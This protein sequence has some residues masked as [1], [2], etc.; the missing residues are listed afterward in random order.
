MQIVAASGAAAAPSS[1]SP[2]SFFTSASSESNNVQVAAQRRYIKLNP[3]GAP[4]VHALPAALSA[5]S[6]HSLDDTVSYLMKSSLT[7]AYYSSSGGAV[8]DSS[9][10]TPPIEMPST[11]GAPVSLAC[12][13][14]PAP[15]FD[16]VIWLRENGRVVPN[17]R[18]LLGKEAV[19]SGD[20]SNE[21]TSS[22][23]KY[24]SARGGLVKVKHE[25][26]SLL[27]DSK[28]DYAPDD[29]GDSEKQPQRQSGE[30]NNDNDDDDDEKE[31]DFSA[32]DTRVRAVDA[33]AASFMRSMLFIKSLRKEDLGLYKCR[34]VNAYGSRTVVYL[35]REKTLVGK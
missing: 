6:P 31:L 21:D 18:L 2:L 13:V 4:V 20:S 30:D 32:E 16:S 33:R 34:V 11:L 24:Y 12:L 1:S 22:I 14:E 7:D 29:D 10:S 25:N 9:S 8:S 15:G 19:V 28:L 5:F 35:V 17:S 27:L 23:N 3:I 26:M